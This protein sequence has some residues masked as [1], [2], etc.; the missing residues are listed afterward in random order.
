[1][2]DSSLCLVDRAGVP[3]YAVGEERFSRVKQDGRFPHRA[4]GSVDLTGVQ[5]VG[6]P[7]LEDAAKPVAS[8]P[9]FASVL[10]PAE[11][12]VTPYPRVWHERLASL[13]LPV[14]H[15]DHHA[16]H[17]YT[18]FVLSGHEEAFV[19]TGD[20]G[21]YTCPVTMGLFHVTRG[22]VE[23]LAEASFSDREP[24]AA[25]YTDVTVLLGFAPCKHEGKVTGLAAHGRPDPAC[26]RAL[27]EL[28]R[29]IRS[30]EHRLYDWV[31]FLDAEV[32][33]FYEVNRYLA[34][35]YRAELPFSDADIARAA[36]DALEDRLRQIGTWI[37][38]AHGTDLPL[39]LSGGL[40][41]N[42]RANQEM[43]RLGF[44]SVFVAPP[45]GDDGLSVGAAVAARDAVD[46][47]EGRRPRR[48]GAG[49]P[50]AMA[51][52]PGTGEVSA[53]LDGAGLVYARPA[54][55]VR[56]LVGR[57]AAGQIV[58][59]VRDRQEFG[60]RAL[61]RRSILC[62]ADDAGVNDRLNGMLRRT[63]FM[64]FAPVLRA[65]RADDVLD[66]GGLSDVRGCLDAMTV[67]VAVRDWVRDAAPAVV[68]VDGTARPQVVTADSDPFL[69]RL[70]SE[71]EERTGIPV[72]VN[73]SFNIHDEPL[74]SDAEDAVAA[75]L[76]AG[77]DVLFLGGALVALADNPTALALARL[78]RRSG[79]PVGRLRHAALRHSFGRQIATGPGRFSELSDTS[80]L[81]RGSI[82]STAGS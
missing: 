71:Y 12:L 40:F 82:G 80:D 77:L 6:V 66:L 41:A 29:R 56:E 19:L 64:P 45:M 28:H 25:F 16:M 75:F 60:P 79:D 2:H 23:R 50:A 14:L 61:G 7:Y 72:L 22:R 57:L 15:F 26:D 18:G 35:R 42:V 4:L 37:S 51:L 20:Y 1:M 30:A 32:P 58:A 33:P 43:A 59:V 3:V 5:A 81:L 47:A 11:H 53:V 78:V 10:H 55:P 13:G 27:W 34:E 36:Q 17:A 31:G 76:S 62:A 70:L 65:E 73:T 8:H 54:D 69:H 49:A 74:V 21:A 63:E 44:P 52:G 68:H 67:C 48:A 9:V 38:A 39:V 46:E 24:L